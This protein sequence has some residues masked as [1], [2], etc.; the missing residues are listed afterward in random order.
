MP[1]DESVE[2]QDEYNLGKFI[3]ETFQF[4]DD[5]KAK[6]ANGTNGYEK[7][8]QAMKYRNKLRNVFE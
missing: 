3:S 7:L 8:Q 6:I 5:N 2:R 1:G 4:I